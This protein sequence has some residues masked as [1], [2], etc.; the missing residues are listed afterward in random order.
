MAKVND[1]ELMRITALFVEDQET[2]GQPRLTDYLRRFPQY[3]DE[4]VEFATYYYA[5]EADLPAP[6]D[7]APELSSETRAALGRARMRQPAMSLEMPASLLTLV[8]SRYISL[9][10]LA[11]ALNL[12]VD[13]VEQ[14]VNLRFVLGTL[15]GELLRRLARA[16]ELPVEVVQRS[17]SAPRHPARSRVAE[18]PLAYTFE[19][20]QDFRQAIAASVQLSSAQRE[21]WQRI[22]EP[23]N[24]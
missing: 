15:P 1:E 11:A 9:A 3:A 2:G 19:P 14:L 4:I 23:E 7:A 16:L 17:L 22:L 10:P 8:K 18:A 5:L 6:A 21:D 12:S 13:L 24:F 20:Q